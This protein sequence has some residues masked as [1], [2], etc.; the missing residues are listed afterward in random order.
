MFK[1]SFLWPHPFEWFV[2]E[3]DE[4]RPLAVVD[5]RVESRIF[6]GLVLNVP[7]ALAGD[8]ALVLET[9]RAAGG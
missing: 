8:R 2:L 7:A 5:G 6:P 1:E 4:Y 9:L 3:E